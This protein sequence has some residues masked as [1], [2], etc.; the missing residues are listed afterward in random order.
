MTVLDEQV[1]ESF[2]CGGC[3]NTFEGEPAG[4]LNAGPMCEDCLR[5]CPD[6]DSEFNLNSGAAHAFN[7]DEFICGRCTR[8]NYI[9]C[10]EC[11]EYANEHDTLYVAW[12]G[13]RVCES[14][15]NDNFHN[16]QYCD[17]LVRD[18]DYDHEDEC[19]SN[20][21]VHDYSYK[22]DPIFY[23]TQDEFDNARTVLQDNSAV[24]RKY[25]KIPYL[26][27]ELEVECE[28]DR[29]DYRAGAHEFKDNEDLIYLKN[30]GSL[31]YGFEIV[32]HPMTLDWAMEN[33]PW[34]K[35]SILKNTNF[36]AWDTSTA[37][38]HVHV[39]R[40]GFE[41]ESHQAR[42][43][44]FFMRNE[45]FLTWLAG[46][47]GSR[48]AQF[49]KQHMVN[50][51]QKLRNRAGSERYMAV[52]LQNSGTLEVRIFRASLNPLRVQMALQLVDAVVNYTEK[53]SVNEMVIGNAFNADTFA[54]WVSEHPRYSILNEYLFR[55][56][57]P[58]EHGLTQI[59]E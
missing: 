55:W 6:C 21:L 37:G 16:C 32:T 7:G 46:R 18:G 28:G 56:T 15:I 4:N 54:K 31:N 53:L 10:S 51:R 47:S 23:H 41:S 38:L 20:N 49:D 14:C 45:K 8:M 44:H 19:G 27:F 25:R 29:E 59:G 22:P 43:V 13:E 17:T 1:V 50:L 2:D 52:N 33:F 40:D 39:S 9:W 26:G 57:E 3:H 48:W 30:D 5:V 42:F 12:V 35:F 36:D 34:D 24:L 11:E 58:F